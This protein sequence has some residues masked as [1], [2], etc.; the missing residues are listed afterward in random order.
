MSVPWGSGWTAL[1]VVES[2]DVIFFDR[3]VC[4]LSGRKTVL[5]LDPKMLTVVKSGSLAVFGLV[6][7]NGP[8]WGR[9]EGS[10]LVIYRPLL[11]RKSTIA[12]ALLVGDRRDTDQPRWP[13]MTKEQRDFNEERIKSFYPKD[14]VE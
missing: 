11:W 6:G 10:N 8:L 4:E 14:I 5:P 3:A 7:D 12:R 1:F 9:V 13:E 2:P